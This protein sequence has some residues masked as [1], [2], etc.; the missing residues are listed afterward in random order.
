MFYSVDANFLGYFGTSGITNVDDAFAILNSLT[1]VSSYSPSLSE[2]PQ[3]SEHINYTA[4]SLELTDVK[5][6]V[7]GLLVEQMG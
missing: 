1:N 4:Q 3:Y 7:L 5:S 2:F 6:S